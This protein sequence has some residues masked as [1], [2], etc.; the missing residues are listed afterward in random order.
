MSKQIK[1]DSGSQG[2]TGVL[3]KIV[4]L[5]TFTLSL[6]GCS[7]GG[8]G[9]AGG[10]GCNLTIQQI[11]AIG[12]INDLPPECLALLPVPENNLLGR[13]FILGTQ[14]DPAGNLLIFVNGT[15]SDGSSLTLAEFETATVT[16]DGTY[17]FQADPPAVPSPEVSVEPVKTGDD[18]LSLGFIT[19]YSFSISDPELNAISGVFSYIL[20]SLSLPPLPQVLEGMAINFGSTVV[21]QQDWT[22]DAG[23]LDAAFDLDPALLNDVNF[24]NGTAFYDA[25]GVSLQRD[26]GLL[27]DGLI[28]RCRPA[29]MQIAFTD[30]TDN[31]SS[32]YTKDTLV[33]I[34]SRT[35]LTFGE[36]RSDPP[37]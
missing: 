13:M 11:E 4:I 31:A 33:P 6:A 32:T 3:G 29:H 22:E 21:V 10:G 36:P 16:I 24:R 34:S 15:A 14:L 5:V 30:G 12:N 2:Y 8:S 25:L 35:R 26:L 19:D 1:S 23:V 28:E 27:D 37:R 9:S 20:D 18:V 17:V 7:G